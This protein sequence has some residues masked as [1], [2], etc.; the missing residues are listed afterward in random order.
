[1][2]KLLAT[3]ALILTL[4]IGGVALAQPDGHA[5]GGHGFPPPQ[6]QEAIAKLPADKAKLVTD[7]MKQMHEKRKAGWEGMKAKRDEMRTLMLA[8]PFDKAA[9]LAKAAEVED[10]RHANATAM[11]QTIADLAGQLTAEE[12][13]TLLDAMPK[14]HWRHGK[15]GAADAKPE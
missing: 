5:G 7:T 4:N 3:T 10:A 1:M 9:Y 15:A 13:K 8:E 11:H 6:L 12:R 14:K 2:K